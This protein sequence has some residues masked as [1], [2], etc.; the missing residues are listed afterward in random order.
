MQAPGVT[1][2]RATLDDLET[3]RGLWRESRLPE[4]EL[5]KRFTEFQV[6]VDNHGWI[7]AAVGLRFAGS[8]GQIHSVAVRRQD[9]EAELL[10]ALGERLLA[11]A[12]Q[13]GTLRLWTRENGEHWTAA[14]FSLA[15]PETKRGLPSA[16]GQPEEPWLTLKLR[17]E[18]LKLIAAEEQLEAY[19]EIEKAKA[20][21]AVRRGR[22]LRVVATVIALA[23]F[24]FALLALVLVLRRSRPAP[25]RNL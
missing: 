24:G 19:L 13:H 1:I 17:D 14:G 22:V 12:Q 7:L 2:R 15:D 10:S 3:L 9:R 20:E 18:P 8:Q 11:I 23:I 16:I 4:Y 21:Q 6:A 25:K 5:E